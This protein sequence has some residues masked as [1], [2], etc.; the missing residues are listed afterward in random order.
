MRE[1]AL[2]HQLV[3]SPYVQG[4]RADTYRAGAEV[5]AAPH[6]GVEYTGHTR[7]NANNYTC[8]APRAKGTEFCM[9]HLRGQEKAIREQG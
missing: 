5:V 1:I 4:V 9:G 6:D 8:Q 7:C 3:G 2:A